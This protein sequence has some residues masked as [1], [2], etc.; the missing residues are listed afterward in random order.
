VAKYPRHVWNQIKG[1]SC[2]DLIRALE[3]DGFEL[4]GKNPRGSVLIYLNPNDRRR[5]TVH[6]HPGKSYGP[7]ML[8]AMFE[9]LG[10]TTEEKLRE[11]G[12]IK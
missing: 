11:V 2:S 6:W 3:A 9:D 5:V 10:W 7:G 1:T 4:D 8:K 12:L